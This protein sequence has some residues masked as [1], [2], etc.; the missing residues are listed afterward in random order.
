ML[1]LTRIAL[2]LVTDL[3]RLAVLLCRSTRSVQA[4]NLFLRRQLALFKERGAPPRRV[5]AAARISLAVLA[6]FF[7]WR[8]ALFVVQPKTM[9]RWHRAG[10]RL[11]WRWKC[12]PGRPWVP[13]ELRE[14]IRRMAQENPV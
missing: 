7:D 14:L 4:E 6:R 3:F 13:I 9:I 5:D 12:R 8:N 1:A 2:Q 10:W 11:F